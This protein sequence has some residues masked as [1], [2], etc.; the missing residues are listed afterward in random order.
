MAEEPS[1][2]QQ[3]IAL[4]GGAALG[5][6]LGWFLLGLPGLFLGPLTGGVLCLTLLDKDNR[7]TFADSVPGFVFLLAGVFVA[8]KSQ[9]WPV[10]AVGYAIATF[11]LVLL[12]EGFGNFINILTGDNERKKAFAKGTSIFL[13]IFAGIYVYRTAS[14]MEVKVAGMLIFMAGVSLGLLDWRPKIS[15]IFRD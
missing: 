2:G 5:A 11:G 15:D 10:K 12:R 6:L 3:F 4:I 9:S 1:E 14:T 8:D 7:R 13:I